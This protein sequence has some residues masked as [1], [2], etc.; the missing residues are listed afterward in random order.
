M[1]CSLISEFDLIREASTIMGATVGA[2]TLDQLVRLFTIVQFVGD[3]CLNELER[4][5]KLEHDADHIY[6]PYN[7]HHRVETILTRHGQIEYEDTR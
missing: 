6:L 1:K 2:M 7:S 4:R 5:G 3:E